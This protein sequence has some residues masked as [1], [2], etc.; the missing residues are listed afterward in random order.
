[1]KA[2]VEG[3]CAVDDLKRWYAISLLEGKRQPK[4]KEKIVKINCKKY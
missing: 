2:A 1:M 4:E 3:V